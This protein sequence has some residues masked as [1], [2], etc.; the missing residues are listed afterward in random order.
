MMEDVT[1]ILV[2]DKSG[3]Y[4]TFEKFFGK[5]KTVKI[6]NSFQPHDAINLIKKYSPEI[7]L[8]G[9]D[10]DDDKLRSVSL[11]YLMG[12]WALTKGREIYITT[13]NTDE[14]RILKDMIPNSFYIP[15]CESIANIIKEKCQ[16]IRGKKIRKN[17]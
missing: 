15:F 5:S 8:L 14:A 10:P 2:F 6:L 9:G 12:E 17:D 1:N 13:W 4:K 7:I 3:K 11:W 16:T